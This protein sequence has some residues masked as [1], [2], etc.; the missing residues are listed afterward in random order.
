MAYLLR[1]CN[2]DIYKAQGYHQ[3]R[4]ASC[5]G[6]SQRSLLSRLLQDEVFSSEEV[7]PGRQNS[8]SKDLGEG[9]TGEVQRPVSHLKE[10]DVQLIG[11]GETQVSWPRGRHVM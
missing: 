2:G 5:N 11:A 10:Q 7:P 3:D 8:P 1:F 9:A 6:A 4:D